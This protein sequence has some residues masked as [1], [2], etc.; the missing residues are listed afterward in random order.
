MAVFEI[1]QDVD[2][3]TGRVGLQPMPDGVVVNRQV[4]EDLLAMTFELAEQLFVGGFVEK[5]PGGG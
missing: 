2:G 1:Q 5:L 4:A 3:S